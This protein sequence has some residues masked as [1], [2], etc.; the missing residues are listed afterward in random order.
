MLLLVVADRHMRGAVGE[1]VGGHQ[2]RVGEQP[3]RGILAV[4]AGFFLEL[5]HPFEPAHA[6]HAIEDPGELGVL[7]DTALV[8][9][10]VLLRIDA[11]RQEGRRHLARRADQRRR[12]LPHGDGMLVD[13]A[14]D[15][16][17]ARLK[18]RETPDGAEIIA[19][20]QIAGRLDA[21]KDE[22]LEGSHSTSPEWRSRHER[23]GPGRLIDRPA[24]SF[25]AGSTGGV[26]AAARC[27]LLRIMPASAPPM[28]KATAK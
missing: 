19:E 8:E 11:G 25:K 10:D 17:V 21:R 5:R 23:T 13:D 4:F 14:I 28:P 18:L 22:R 15:A 26:F 6:G 1:N 3:D 9:D 2:G 24:Q 20:V 7:E 27:T 16:I 12:I